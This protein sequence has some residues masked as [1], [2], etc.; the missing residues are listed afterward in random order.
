MRIQSSDLLNKL[1]KCLKTFLPS[2]ATLINLKDF[3]MAEEQG[4]DSE[5]YFFILTY[6]SEGLNQRKEF[7]LK[8]YRESGKSTHALKEFAI[9]KA[10]KECSFPVPEAYYLDISNTINEKPFIIMEKIPGKNALSF[11]ND[12]AKAKVLVDK[13]AQI[14]SR[15]HKLDPNCI[16]E[17]SVL[18]EQYELEQRNLLTAEILMKKTPRRFF[19]NCS[20]RQ[21]RFLATVKRLEELKPK[22]FQPAILH[23]DYTLGHFVVSNRS[24][25]IVDWTDVVVG[26]PAWDVALAY[27][28]LRIG[29]EREKLDL[30]EHFI[31]SYTRHAGKTLTNWQI[32]KDRVILKLALRSGLSLFPPGARSFFGSLVSLTFG[33]VFRKLAQASFRHHYQKS[34]ATHHNTVLRNLDDIQNYIIRYMEKDRYSAM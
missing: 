14:L 27:H 15:L 13:M 2:D 5:V 16:P 7:A 23:M 12:E 30:G 34:M 8:L 24:F 6:I 9:L 20:S 3:R 22:K 28:Y 29:R 31:N 32:Y 33:N 18:R 25:A 10:L 19:R 26:D 1:V 4:A 17:S 21:L 11:L